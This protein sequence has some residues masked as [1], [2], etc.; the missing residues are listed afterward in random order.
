MEPLIVFNIGGLAHNEI[1]SLEK[2]QNSNVINHRIYI[3]STCVMNASEYMRQLREID[4]EYKN[5]IGK[6]CLDDEMIGEEEDDRLIKNDN[7][8]KGNLDKEN[9]P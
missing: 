2:L 8:P 6:D 3:G 5:E 4:K 7:K 1:A 9:I